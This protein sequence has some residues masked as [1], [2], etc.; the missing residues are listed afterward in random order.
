MTAPCT[1]RYRQSVSSSF[2]SHSDT[3]PRG[4]NLLRQPH[5]IGAART[6]LRG[7]HADAGPVAQL[8]DLIEDVNHI[9]PQREGLGAGELELVREPGVDLVVGGQ[10]RA[11]VVAVAQAA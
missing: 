9:E 10:M 11:V 8:V 3:P 2:N 4:S 6:E 5:Q 7:E 1:L